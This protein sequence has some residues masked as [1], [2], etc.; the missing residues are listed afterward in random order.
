MTPHGFWDWSPRDSFDWFG[1]VVGLVG[2]VLTVL[3]IIQAKGAKDAAL[4]AKNSVWKR[5]ASDSFRGLAELAVRLAFSVRTQRVQDSAIFAGLLVENLP[6][7]MARFK[8][9]ITA[10]A[11]K[12]KEML[13][14]MNELVNLLVDP[15]FFDQSANIE[16][17]NRVAASSRDLLKEISGRLMNEIQKEQA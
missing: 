3:A 10:N 1:L 7:E 9:H 8:Q 14:E 2:L 17:A 12:L 6:L 16:K 4:D 11:D 15:K 13:S 5:D